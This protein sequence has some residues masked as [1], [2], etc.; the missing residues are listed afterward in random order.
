M[1]AVFKEIYSYNLVIRTLQFT[2]E[3]LRFHLPAAS[4]A[5]APE[6]VSVDT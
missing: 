1:K 4:S 6:I 5:W 2:L 3:N